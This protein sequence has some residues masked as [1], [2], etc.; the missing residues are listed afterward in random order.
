VP[1]GGHV[2]GD[3]LLALPPGAQ[4]KGSVEVVE[5]LGLGPG[6]LEGDEALCVSPLAG[7][8]GTPPE[9]RRARMIRSLMLGV[10][11]GVGFALPRSSA[12]CVSSGS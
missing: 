4:G 10:P 11:A 2:V 8:R 5:T 1:E 7:G 3:Q 9:A 12:Q 6:P